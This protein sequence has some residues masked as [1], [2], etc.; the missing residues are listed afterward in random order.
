V[1]PAGKSNRCA[2]LMSSAVEM[3]MVQMLLDASP[4]VV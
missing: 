3:K 1:A 4:A 2:P